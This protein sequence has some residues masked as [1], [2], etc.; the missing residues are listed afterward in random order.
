M[1][2]SMSVRVL[3]EAEGWVETATKTES[4]LSRRVS[5]DVGWT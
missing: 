2:S 1:V 3:A 4:S 5:I